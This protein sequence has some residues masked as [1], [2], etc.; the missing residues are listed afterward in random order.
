M[1]VESVVGMKDIK[2]SC[3]CSHESDGTIHINIDRPFHLSSDQTPKSTPGHRQ[4]MVF[5]SPLFSTHPTYQL[6]KSML[7]D[8]FN[9]HALESIPLMGLE[10]VICVS[11][12]PM[13]STSDAAPDAKEV[14]P[15]VHLRVFTLKLLATPTRLPKVQ[16][17]PM[18]PSIDFSIRR[19]QFGAPEILSLAYKR[20]KLDKKDVEKGLGKK[21][22]N[23]ETDDMGDLVGRIHLGKQDLS[24]LQ[25][26]KM[27]G[28]KDG[29]RAKVAQNGDEEATGSG[30][31]GGEGRGREQRAS[32]AAA[33]AAAATVHGGREDDDAMSE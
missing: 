12:G 5:Q 32:K 22:K 20:P 18:G 7:L 23:I 14:L 19:T 8:F 25:V 2:V 4:L 6:I 21:R 17:I 13:A 27:K 9:G 26:R 15:L 1:G 31:G 3:M 16:L 30:A 10:G 33:K 28:L 11:A 24:N 29:K